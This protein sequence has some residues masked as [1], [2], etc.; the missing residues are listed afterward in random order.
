[1]IDQ[2]KNIDMSGKK[3]ASFDVKSLFTNVP[4]E[5]ALE[6]LQKLLIT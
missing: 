4:V 3:L 5:G 6:A 1:M 2:L